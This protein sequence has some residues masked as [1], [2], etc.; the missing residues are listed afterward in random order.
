MKPAASQSTVRLLSGVAVLLLLVLLAWGGGRLWAVVQAKAAARDVVTPAS[1]RLER[2]LTLLDRNEKGTE[3]LA[4]ASAAM[5]SAA[6]AQIALKRRPDTEQ[7]DIQLALEYLGS[8]ELIVSD[9]RAV[10]AKHAEVVIAS[11][12]A[13]D[14]AGGVLGTRPE[15][16]AAGLAAMDVT[17]D[18]LARTMDS[19][20]QSA[21]ILGHDLAGLKH[22]NEQVTR[23]LGNSAALNSALL[24]T[25]VQRY[26]KD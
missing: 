19:E 8:V 20:T 6:D 2:A 14:S 5:A 4:Q 9:L 25:L 1:L 3:M 11:R 12:M 16:V 13:S 18:G 22:Q 21:Y 10:A 26:S 17:T 15:T 7:R 23:E 24:A